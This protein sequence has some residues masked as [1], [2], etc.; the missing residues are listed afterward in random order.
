MRNTEVARL[1]KNKD[2]IDAILRAINDNPKTLDRHLVDVV[3]RFTEQNVTGTNISKLR[4]IAR[5]PS[6]L[7]RMRDI[8]RKIIDENHKV[9]GEFKVMT[10]SSLEVA[11]RS[12]QSKSAVLRQFYDEAVIPMSPQECQPKGDER[13]STGISYGVD[14]LDFSPWGRPDG[15][16]DLLMEISE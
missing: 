6:K 2:C 4:S 16:D 3:S 15:I 7:E 13:Y 8:V 9:V 14:V 5:I 12:G 1:A 10:I 11:K